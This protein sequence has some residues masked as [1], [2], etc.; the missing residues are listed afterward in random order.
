MA[1]KISIVDVWAGD[2]VNKPGMLARVLEGVSNAGAK[3]EFMIARKASDTTSRV[4]ISPIKGKKV[5]Q[6]AADVGLVPTQNMHALCI[7]GTDRP[8][9]GADITRAVAAQGI[10]LRGASAAAIG[11]RAV[12]Y[13]AFDSAE[14]S[15]KAA[16]IAKKAV[17]KSKKR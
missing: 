12:V 5:K 7:E 8:A 4:F 17:K 14:D 11:K 6:A 1:Y 3:L 13:L 10:N 9:L 16:K 15:E 2:I